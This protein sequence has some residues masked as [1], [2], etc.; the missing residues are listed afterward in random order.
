MELS[1]SERVILIMLADIMKQLKIRSDIDPDFV[2][3]AVIDGQPWALD[4]QYASL[5]ESSG[6]DEGTVREVCDILDMWSD[7]EMSYMQL[8]PA[9]KARLEAEASPFGKNVVFKGFDGN[10]EGEHFGIAN[11]LIE[12]L[13]RFSEFKARDLNS[14]SPSIEIYRRMLLAY[15]PILRSLH[16]ESLNTDQLIQILNEKR[17]PANRD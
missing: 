14:H 12:K 11:F 13:G 10:R 15:T 9:D 8:S 17:H 4:W 7:L 1:K 5:F 3:A 16:G 6:P 2:K